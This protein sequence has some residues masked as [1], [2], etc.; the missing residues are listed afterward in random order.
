MSNTSTYNPPPISTRETTS[1]RNHFGWL[2]VWNGDIPPDKQ[3]TN[4]IRRLHIDQGTLKIII[5]H[6][7][8]YW[9]GFILEFS[10]I[11][12]SERLRTHSGR[13]HWVPYDESERLRVKKSICWLYY[14]YHGL[15]FNY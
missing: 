7:E 4:Q 8:T 15:G 3:Q 1:H 14:D 11:K 13:T 2:G 12:T 10:V 5:L 6:W 9:S